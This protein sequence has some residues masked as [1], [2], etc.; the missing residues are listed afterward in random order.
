MTS[1]GEN[2]WAQR[3]LLANIRQELMAPVTAILGY[4]EMLC[5][6]AATNG[7]D[8]LIADLDH[9]YSAAQLLSELSISLLDPERSANL[10][11]G[12]DL[13]AAQSMIRHDLRNPLNAIKG[14]SELLIEDAADMEGGLALPD[15]VKLLDEA[16]QL[17]AKLESIIDFSRAEQADAG[18]DILTVSM[19]DHL[20]TVIRP[21]S[22]DHRRKALPGRILVVDDNGSNREFLA[23]RLVRDG[24]VVDTAEGGLQ[25]LEMVDSEAYDVILLDLMMPGVSGFEVL[26]RLKEEPQH[27]D[28]RVIMISGFNEMESMVRC[29]EA[30]ADD[31]LPKPIN[32]TLLSARID[33][34]LER[35]Q[36]RD[37]EQFYLQKI[38]EEKRKSEVLLLNIL[39]AGIIARMHKGE[40]RIADRFDDVSVLFADLVGF[41]VL[42]ATITAQE[43]VNCLNLLVSEF[44]AAAKRLG[45]EKIKTI[46]DAYLA[47]AGLPEPRA[48]HAEACVHLAQAM[49]AATGKVNREGGYSLNL[50]IG[51]NSGPVVAGVIGSHK[52]AYDIWGDTVNTAARM[53]SYSMPGR[54]HLSS[55]TAELLAGRFPLEARGAILVRG[56]GE[57]ETFF[58][59]QKSGSA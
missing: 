48:D 29:I 47:A 14:Y 36:A 37:R 38:E 45:V 19:V 4:S 1:S 5:Q 28:I 34:S 50:R 59:A 39:P 15:L 32:A 25:A 17:L 56:K 26:T 9:I 31:Y 8:G 54:I 10:Q 27:A 22:E 7:A 20:Q 42:S 13:L 44:D 11:T 49:V 58:L 6:D 43:L 55:E 52:Y 23:R 33:A 2:H 16:N 24:H 18:T 21:L 51:I 41:T 40:H 46:G 53:E 57:M 30:G 3:A 12:S 35:K